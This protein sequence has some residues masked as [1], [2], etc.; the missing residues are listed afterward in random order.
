LLT[1]S[2]GS[3]YSLYKFELFLND[4][5]DH[6]R[7]YYGRVRHKASQAIAFDLDY[8]FERTDLADFQTLRMG[9]TWRF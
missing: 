9:F 3:Y 5:R 2:V 8:E 6:V 7:T 4:E 1:L